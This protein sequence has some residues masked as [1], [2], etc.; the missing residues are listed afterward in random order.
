MIEIIRKCLPTY[1]VTG[2]LGE[3][4]YGTVYRIEDG[5]KARAAKVVPLVVERSR[6]A[7]TASEMDSR[8]SQDFHAVEQYYEKIEGPGVLKIHDFHLVGKEV[9]ERE[10]RGYLVI[11][12]ELCAENLRDHVLDAKDGLS[13]ARALALMRELAVI[14]RRLTSEC[15]ETFLVTDLKPG[16]LLFTTSGDLVVGDLGGLKRLSSVSST[17][18]AQFTPNWAA[19]ETI[20]KA[21]SAKVPAII[22]SYGLVCYFLWEGTLPYE[23]EDFIERL[24]LLRDKGVSFTRSD[25]PRE[26]VDFIARCLAFEPEDRFKGFDEVASALEPVAAEA[27]P[28]RAAPGDRR[29]RR[30]LRAEAPREPEPAPQTPPAAAYEAPPGGD[31]AAAEEDA[32]PPAE[33]APE[34]SRRRRPAS[35]GRSTR[36]RSAAQHSCPTCGK[37]VRAPRGIP[38][39]RIRCPH[40]ERPLSETGPLILYF[41]SVG[42]CLAGWLLSGALE[43]FAGQAGVRFPLAVGWIPAGILTGFALRAA[44]PGFSF[45]HVFLTALGFSLGA[46]LARRD[47]SSLFSLLWVAGWMLG[48][49]GAGMAAKNA[50]PGFSVRH[51]FLTVFFWTTGFVA[52]EA[53]LFFFDDSLA[54]APGSTPGERLAQTAAQRGLMELLAA[55]V[56]LSATFLLLRHAQKARLKSAGASGQARRIASDS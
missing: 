45:R 3:G 2:S 55:F 34:P 27:A 30:P 25:V 22:Y 51:L 15:G 9:S 8:I 11:L 36:E 18:R 1:K 31:A 20:L 32:P 37:K 53:G 28:D 38:L 39:D 47:D 46:F 19:P 10:A 43:F 12:M 4:I 5:L 33:S 26:A 48:S 23:E 7:P 17:A 56:G 44:A 21:E 35:S 40:C 14:L 41:R 6:L 42:L 29:I 54:G 16:N 49:F 52:G 24:R 13:P 50:Q